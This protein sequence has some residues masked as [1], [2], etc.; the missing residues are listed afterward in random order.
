MTLAPV[1]DET[2]TRTVAIAR[3]RSRRR[4]RPRNAILGIVGILVFLAIW[5]IASQ[6]GLVNPTYLP[7]PTVVIPHLFQ[8]ATFPD[9]WLAV[10]DT[11]LAWGLGMLIALVLACVLG[12]IIGLSPFLRRATNSTVE[13]LRPIP[14]V[15]LIPLAVLLFGIRI[16][17]TL[18]LVVYAAFWQI[19]IQVLY[20]VADVDQVAM[21]TGRSYGFSKWQ[22][23]RDIIFPTALPYL[24]T[25][26]RLASAIALILAITA[27]LIIGTPG[28]G[29]EIAFAQN[30]GNY[31][32]MYALSI[33][34]GLL[35]VLINI[36]ARAM[37]RR[38]LAWHTS[39]RGDVTT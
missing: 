8:I 37:E 3:A 7:P 22:R 15:A 23:I 27:Q 31:A 16:E 6:T 25:G 26:I 38:L 39:V 11:M 2:V 12:V 1:G 29:R 21:S 9:F 5:E 34:T 20:G 14:S 17:S 28:L 32:T 36:G 19:F 10:G 13:F 18:L 30:A 33:A 35:G 24:M 4:F